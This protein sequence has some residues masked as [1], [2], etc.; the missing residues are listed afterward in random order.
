MSK[1]PMDVDPKRVNLL[2]K[3]QFDLKIATEQAENAE[4]RRRQAQMDLDTLIADVC[5]L[6]GVTAETH[7]IDPLTFKYVAKS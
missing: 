4:E 1:D 2:K 3:A 7:G 6:G 5:T